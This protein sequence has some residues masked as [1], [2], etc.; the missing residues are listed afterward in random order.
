MSALKK[1]EFVIMASGEILLIGLF[2]LAFTQEFSSTA[3]Q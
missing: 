2:V 3:G 1:G